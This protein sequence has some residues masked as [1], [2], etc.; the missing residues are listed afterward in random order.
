MPRSILFHIKHLLKNKIRASGLE[1]NFFYSYL[2]A[3]YLSLISS[4]VFIPQ[5]KHLQIYKS[6]IP[7]KD[8]PLV[9]DIGAFCGIETA[10]FLRLGA[11]V[12][13]V[14][15]DLTSLKVLK[16]RFKNNK[17]VVI[18][19]KAVSDK[20]D[21]EDFFVAESGSGFNTL[22]GKWKDSLGDPGVNRFGYKMRFGTTRKVATTTLAD[23]IR[24]FGVPDY[25]K[26][27]VEG[28]EYKVL[29]SLPQPI[30]ALS[31]E[32]NMPEFKEEAIASL[33]HLYDISGDYKF[34]YSV[35][36]GLEFRDF[37]TYNDFMNFFQQTKLRCMDI[38]AI[39]R[40]C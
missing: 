22:S 17:K 15:P 29:S 4:P 1:N 13:A 7:K 16:I 12:I 25:V 33:G 35:D 21:S 34:N 5:K 10:V 3:F 19:N 26:I 30:P 20:T 27:D 23:L 32:V 14:D 38:H 11:K 39:C 37:L 24:E 36:N 28:Y 9:F 8:N 18:V 2:Y 40:S 31:F 6:L